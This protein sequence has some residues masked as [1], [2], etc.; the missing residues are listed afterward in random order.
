M[1]NEG[2]FLAIVFITNI[3][4]G[5]TG[6]AGTVLAMPVSIFLVGIDSAKVVLNLLG[7]LASLWIVAVSYKYVKWKEIIIVI[8]LMIAGSVI[9]ITLFSTIALS[10]LL[11]VYGMFIAL[12]ALKGIFVKGE[13]NLKE[14]VLFLVVFVAGIIHGMFVSGGPLLMLYIINK[15]K[16]KSSF[17]ANIAVIWIV[18]NSFL[19]I[20]HY[21]SG[22]ITAYNLRLLS[23][24]IVPLFVG[25]LVG[26]YLYKRVDQK[27]FLNLTYVLLLISGISLIFK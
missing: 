2:I 26:N 18:L 17:R 1:F 12:V 4:Q 20:T 5:I 24:T 10:W 6:F 3:I 27:S 25:V 22:L 7:L 16:D 15:F 8:L 14:G 21:N 23:M 13:W 9:G 11:K 19:A